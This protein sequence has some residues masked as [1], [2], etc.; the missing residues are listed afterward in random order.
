LPRD[1]QPQAFEIVIRSPEGTTRV[2]LGERTLT[3][4]RT[5]DADISLKDDARAS[6]R[7]AEIALGK[8]GNIELCDLGSAN[9]TSLD[10]E[11][12]HGTVAIR[13]GQVIQIGASQLT[14]EPVSV[15]VAASPRVARSPSH[16]RKWLAAGV[17]VAGVAVAIAVTSFGGDPATSGNEIAAE[18]RDISSG[19][20]ATTPSMPI[21]AAPSEIPAQ[22]PTAD[23]TDELRDFDLALMEQR[24]PAAERILRAIRDPEQSATAKI[25]LDDAIAAYVEDAEREAK[26]LVLVKRPKEAVEQLKAALASLP[27]KHE[28]RVRL[29]ES[30]LDIRIPATSPAAVAKSPTSYPNP[31]PTA[32]PTVKEPTSAKEAS[33]PSSKVGTA[34]SPRETPGSGNHV[35]SAKV[36]EVPEDLV[37]SFRRELHR[38]EGLVRNFDGAAARP[39]FLEAKGKLAGH[40]ESEE[41]IRAERGL[42]NCDALATLIPEL[43]KSAFANPGAPP[44]IPGKDGKLQSLLAL[45]DNG[46]LFSGG[47]EG[48]QRVPW[49]ETPV[50]TLVAI[51]ER[52]PLS[53]T[54][55]VAGARILG[56]KG[57]VEVDE[58]LGKALKREPS[59]K[60]EVD[61][62]LADHRELDVLPEGG[63]AYVDGRFWSPTELARKDLQVQ[64]ERACAALKSPNREQRTEAR[65]VL[66]LLGETA[67]YSYQ[68]ALS[69]SFNLAKADLEKQPV[70]GQL[71]AFADLHADYRERRKDALALIFDTEKYPYPYRVPEA[72]PEAAANYVKSQPEVERLT[73]L[74]RKAYEDPK[75]VTIPAAIREGIARLKEIHGW[76][77]ESPD[78]ASQ[79]APLWLFHLPEAD[80]IRVKDMAENEEDR[81]RLTTSAETL[82]RN[83]AE[84]GSATAAEQEQCRITN[85]YRIMMGRY[86][87]RIYDPMAKASHDHCNDMSTIGFFSHTSPVEGKRT[88]YDRLVRQGMRP[89]GASEN[90]AINSSP[91]GAHN[92]WCRSPGH[93]RNLL[94]SSWRIMG[95]GNVGRYYCQNFGISDSATPRT[96]ATDK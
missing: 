66:L 40:E 6:R 43:M 30:I 31:S 95:P 34:D 84:P 5:P 67:L 10:G 79:E 88:P 74:V 91:L 96:G 92:A 53:P 45:D 71:R 25:R 21:P 60:P 72:T 39:I 63:F 68:R 44:R 65:N 17:L 77:L 19:P 52:A 26:G 29:A 62:A 16:S 18:N 80:T 3:I 23:P 47:L 73:G 2:A 50:K 24:F 48:S 22:L 42:R 70:Y 36:T 85:E 15:C 56:L 54:A 49:A 89:N 75:S 35:A 51:V 86:A 27:Q 11:A 76:M 38:A 61:Q 58:L 1:H 14:V 64:I 20:P 82:K 32:Q 9:G 33:R 41:H 12:I 78:M 55:A 4:G 46:L 13:P 7:H 8:G 57:H 93:H 81:R 59:L 83:L 69:E 87:V 28:G 37:A 94:G 90:I